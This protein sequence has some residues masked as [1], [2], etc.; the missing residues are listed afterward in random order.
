MDVVKIMISSRLLDLCIEDQL[1]FA[2]PS[3]FDRLL[4]EAF[5]F[6]KKV[7]MGH[8]HLVL[9]STHVHVTTKAPRLK[10]IAAFF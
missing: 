5:F 3:Q 4:S 9:R 1:S 7:M 6:S 8:F 2:S 10:E